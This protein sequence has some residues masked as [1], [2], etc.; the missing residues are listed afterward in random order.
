MTVEHIKN[1]ID[2]IY[3]LEKEIPGVG[4]TFSVYFI[5]DIDNILIEP[6]PGALIPAILAAANE[7]GISE[8]QYIIPTHIHMDHAGGSGKLASLLSKV[9]VIA[10]SQGARHLVNPDRLIRSTT[11]SFGTDF[12]KTWG[13]IEPVPESRIIIVRD[14]KKLSINGRDMI[15][16]ETPGHAPHHIVVFDTKTG[17]LFCGESLGLIYT[18]GTQPLSSGAP[19]NFDLE[20]YIN[21]MKRLRELPL[22]LLIYSHGGISWQPKESILM[23][24][25][26]VKVIGEIILESLKTKTEK[27]AVRILDDYIQDNYGA[28]MSEYTLMNNVLGYGGYFKKKG[29]I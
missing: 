22:K 5:K 26:N 15:F 11:M 21:T 1:I 23:A 19:P 29:L 2:N 24:I 12:E 9:S 18:P 16:F 3:C 8:F 28:K 14:G 20:L 6:G 25:K 7:L 10:N 27:T 13:T 17:G 4:D